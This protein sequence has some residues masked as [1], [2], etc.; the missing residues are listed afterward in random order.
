MSTTRSDQI[1]AGLR[2]S[3]PIA[4]GYA[5]LGVAYGLFAVSAGLDWWWV[6]IAAVVIYAGSMEFLA[7]AMI[8]TAMPLGAVALTTVLVNF[9]HVFYGLSFPL[10]RIKSTIGRGY[11]IH[12]LTDETYAVVASRDQGQLSG[13]RLL[14]ISMSAH[15]Y[16]VSGAAIGAAL[17]TLATFDAGFMEFALTALFVMLTIDAY[18]QHPNPGLLGLALAIAVISWWLFPEQLLITALS[19]YAVIA[20]AWQWRRQQLSEPKAVLS[21]A[22]IHHEIT[23]RGSQRTAPSSAHRSD[24]AGGS[25]QEQE[26]DR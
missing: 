20:G 11:A 21:Q 24:R 16:W 4:M 15:V 7:V 18:R 2:D 25:V 12:A 8:T 6:V 17:A 5:P 1:R 22:P 14:T 13:P 9:R 26:M 3:F 10:R 23:M 19:A